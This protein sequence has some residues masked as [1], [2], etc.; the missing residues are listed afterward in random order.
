MKHRPVCLTGMILVLTACGGGDSTASLQSLGTIKAAAVAPPAGPPL[1]NIVAFMGYS[2]IARWE[3]QDYDTTNPVLNFGIGNQTTVQMLGRFGEVLSSGAGVVVI[4]GGLNDLY[5]LGPKTAN[6]DSIASMATQAKAAGIRVILTSLVP[7]SFSYATGT[8]PTSSDIFAMSEALEAL[9][10]SQGYLYADFFDA[11][12]LPDGAQD[13]SLTI[14][15]VHPNAAGYAKLWAV[16]E[17]LIAE[18]L[19]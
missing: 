14:D 8:A 11:M 3:L 5:Q 7:D 6:I 18:D 10:Q 19:K 15:G 2:I 13:P 1:S 12:R 17:P 4:E 9:A 16:L